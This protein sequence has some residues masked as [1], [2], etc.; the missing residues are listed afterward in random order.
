MTVLLSGGVSGV[1]R[2]GPAYPKRTTDVGGAVGASL[3]LRLG[4]LLSAQVNADD[5]IYKAKFSGAAQSS[6]TTQNDLHFSFGLG[7]GF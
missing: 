5:Y 2:S 6:T 1:N 7:S 4:G 3:R